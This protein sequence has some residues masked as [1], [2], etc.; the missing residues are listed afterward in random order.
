MAIAVATLLVAVAVVGI[1]GVVQN[2]RVKDSAERAIGHD[3]EVEDIGEDIQEAIASIRE[4]HTEISLSG[5]TNEN[6][7]RLN[8]AHQHYLDTIERLRLVDI[9]SLAVIGPD[10]FVRLMAE[11]RDAFVPATSLFFTDNPGFVAASDLGNQRLLVLEQEALRI[12]EAGEDLTASAFAR[13]ENASET[14][15]FVLISVLAGIGL[16]GVTLFITAGQIVARLRRANDQEQEASRQL[17]S[18][19]QAKTDFI[20]DAS[21]ELRTPLTLIRGNAELLLGTPHDQPTTDGLSEI[22][23]ESRRLGRLVDDMLFLAQA[24]AERAP[25]ELELA[26]G[27]WLFRQLVGPCDALARSRDVNLATASSGEADVL[28]DPER[29]KQAVLIVVDNAAKHSTPHNDITLHQ[30]VS[31]NW[32]VIE[33]GDTGSGIP[34]EQLQHVFER[35]YQV[36]DRRTRSGG[37]GLGLAIAKSILDAHKGAIEIES[38]PDVG[39]TV[40]MRI[41]VVREP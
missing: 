4:I 21:H 27:G 33:I 1:V 16:V 41:P 14:A 26:P 12:N 10:D 39:T 13:V 3:A 38:T 23:G 34:A 8:S 29:I 20:A 37:A 28:V 30:S 7:S 15:R 25:M 32:L 18:A 24:D 6:L 35:F 2:E 31:D 22:L 17:A 36:G 19:L 5:P 11:Y 9:A 40:T